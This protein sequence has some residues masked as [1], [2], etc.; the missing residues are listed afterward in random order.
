VL[1]SL[2]RETNKPVLM[3]DGSKF[4]DVRYLNLATSLLLLEP[5]LLW[6]LAG[7]PA[8]ISLSQ[9]LERTSVSVWCLVANVTSPHCCARVLPLVVPVRFA[10]AGVEIHS[11]LNF[12]HSTLNS[13]APRFGLAPEKPFPINSLTDAAWLKRGD[14]GAAELATKEAVA[15]SATSSKSHFVH[16]DAQKILPYT[17]SSRGL[18]TRG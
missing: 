12:V 2:V 16:H 7:Q 15:S 5:W 8:A 3:S 17:W 18:P 1:G 11:T 6:L 9:R 13:L 10:E 14:K 4:G